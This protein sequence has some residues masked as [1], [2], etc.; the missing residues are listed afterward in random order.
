MSIVTGSA[1]SIVAATIAL[2]SRHESALLNRVKDQL[3]FLGFE[4]GDDRLRV[5]VHASPGHAQAPCPPSS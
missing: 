3:F 1:R 4:R 5:V 2:P